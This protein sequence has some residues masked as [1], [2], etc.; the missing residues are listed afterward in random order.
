V[1]GHSLLFRPG[2]KAFAGRFG[3][4]RRALYNFLILTGWP[5]I[6]YAL[7]RRT[8]RAPA[9]MPETPDMSRATYRRTFINTLQ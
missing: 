4:G 9:L 6:I 8:A 2:L 1:T 7:P 3:T 5:C